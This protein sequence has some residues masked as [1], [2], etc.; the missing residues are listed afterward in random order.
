MGSGRQDPGQQRA[1]RQLSDAAESLRRD[2]V[3][4]RIKRGKQSLANNQMEEARAGERGV[5]RS[6]NDLSERL[7]AAEQT[8]G[9]QGSQQN[10][11][12]ALDRT[13]RLADD[14]ESLRRRMDE[15]SQQQSGQQRGN[16]RGNQQGSQQ[17]R[18]Q[19]GQQQG[20]QQSGQQQGREGQQGDGQQAGS[21]K[22]GGQQRGGQQRGSQQAGQQGSDSQTQIGNDFG[23]VGDDSRQLRSELRERL[24]DA[25]GLRREWGSTSGVS[26]GKLGEIVEELRRMA[27]GQMRG[28]A[29]TAAALKAQVID[30]LRQLELELSRRM[31]EQLGRTN[32]RLIDE[33]AAPER[34]RKAV[35]DY[36]KRLSGGGKK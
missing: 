27:D 23:G 28:D 11:E 2:R 34:Y 24:R 15:N 29:Q 20:R 16:Q 4:E 13:R 10:G 36:Y 5:E 12:E 1:A 18:Q 21:Q 6:L 26:V 22:G 30:P 19:S 14:L 35:E 8:A 3:A 25:E 32:L 17:G 7:Q 33:G 9:R 31:R